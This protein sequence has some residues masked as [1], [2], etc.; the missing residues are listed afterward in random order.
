VSC[1]DDDHV[2]GV[3][4]SRRSVCGWH[5]ITT[6][7]QNELVAGDLTRKLNFHY[8]WEYLELDGH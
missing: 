7:S 4:G 5:G 8:D 2:A 1:A 6:A 3:L